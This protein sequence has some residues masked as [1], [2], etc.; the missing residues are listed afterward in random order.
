MVK[1]KL[2]RFVRQGILEPVQ[3]GGNANATPVFWQWKQ[4]GALRP[5]VDLKLNINGKVRDEFYPIPD[6]ETIDHIP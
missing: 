4:N 1:E 3:P 6:M 5:R 2:E